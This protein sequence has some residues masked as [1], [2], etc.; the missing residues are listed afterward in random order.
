MVN[1]AMRW[2]TNLPFL[3][4]P[5]LVQPNLASRLPGDLGGVSGL[6]TVP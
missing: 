6:E 3:L 2:A 4:F 5:N 1:S